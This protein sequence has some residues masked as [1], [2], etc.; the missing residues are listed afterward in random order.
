MQFRNSAVSQL[1]SFA[2]QQFCCSAVSQLRFARRS[3]YLSIAKIEQA[4]ANS[5]SILFLSAL[6][7]LNRLKPIR[8]LFSL[9]QHF[10]G[11]A[12]QQ[13]RSSAVLQLRFGHLSRSLS[14]V[15]I[16]QAEANSPS[17]L[18]LSALPQ[19]NRL[20]P[21][22]PPFSLSQQFRNFAVPQFLYSAVLQFSNF[23]V[24][25]FYILFKK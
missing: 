13:F 21:I 16:E 12:F 25:Q 10:R 7:K 23:A 14:I 3:R 4:K 15:A 2:V 17:I 24:L 6:P 18:V 9:S 19:L 8:P 20:K 22:R 1:S 11:S 5:P